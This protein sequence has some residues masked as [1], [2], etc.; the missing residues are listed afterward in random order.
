[1]IRQIITLS[2]LLLSSAS[3]ACTELPSKLLPKVAMVTMELCRAEYE[4]GYSTELKSPLWVG[5]TLTAAEVKSQEI[6]KNM[7]K[8][9]PNLPLGSKA[10]LSDYSKSG[11]DRGHM[12]PAGDA[13]TDQGLAESFYLSNMVPQAKELNRGEWSQLE[14]NLREYAV[15]K[16]VI[17]IFT[18][19]IFSSAPETIGDNRLPV[20]VELYKVVYEAYSNEVFTLIVPNQQITSLSP[21]VSNLETLRAKTGIDFFAGQNV[22]ELNAL[23]F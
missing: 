21:Y 16:Q 18:G 11:Y 17:Y 12:F 20:P 8:A 9:D 19:P 3:L 13:A 4:V 7:F 23:P 5:E 22:R 2:A 10:M 1:M 14:K 6:R 15:K